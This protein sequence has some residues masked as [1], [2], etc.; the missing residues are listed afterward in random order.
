[1]RHS[2]AY[3]HRLHHGHLFPVVDAVPAVGLQ[4]GVIHPQGLHAFAPRGF[5]GLQ[6]VLPAFGVDVVSG[7]LLVAGGRGSHPEERRRSSGGSSQRQ[8]FVHAASGRRQ[9]VRVG[10]R[11]A[12]DYGD[13]F[14]WVP[15]ARDELLEPL[16]VTLGGGAIDRNKSVR[17]T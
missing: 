8:P 3:H 14:A 13:A 7:G 12:M 4:R 17:N 5:R 9:G 6:C 11:D 2:K 1:M 10:K 15:A 16:M